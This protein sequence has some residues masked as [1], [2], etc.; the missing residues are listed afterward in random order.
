MSVCAKNKEFNRWLF[1]SLVRRPVNWS[2]DG[3]TLQHANV[4]IVVTST[5]VVRYDGITVFMPPRAARR[6]SKIFR[7]MLC[8][9]A[10]AVRGKTKSEL[11]E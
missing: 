4:D 9:E 5:G 1:Q 10:L 11:S 6:L 8:T 3:A 7:C 2:R